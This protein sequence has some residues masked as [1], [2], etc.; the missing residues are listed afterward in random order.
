[1]HAFVGFCD[2]TAGTLLDLDTIRDNRD[3]IAVW[4]HSSDTNI[5]SWRNDNSGGG[6]NTDLNP[7]TPTASG[8]VNNY[9]IYTDNGGT[10][11]HVVLNGTDNV[12]TTDLPA[13]T[14]ELGFR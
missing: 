6:N 13:P 3:G 11:W 8:G 10:S 9:S 4:A 1:M 14:A 12:Y 7:A 5:R 2:G